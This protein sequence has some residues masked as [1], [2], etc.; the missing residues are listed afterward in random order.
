MEAKPKLT[1]I[2]HEPTEEMPGRRGK[3]LPLVGPVDGARNVD[4]HINILNVDSGPG[5]THYHAHSENIYIVLD[6]MVEVTIE[7]RKYIAK[8]GDVAFIPPG[9]HHSAGTTGDKPARIIEIY[10][11]PI[12]T[13]SGRDFQIV[14]GGYND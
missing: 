5:P 4:V 11:P 7:G 13:S 2:D 9:V 10:A 1:R 6:G 14:S 12:A 8:P 3:R